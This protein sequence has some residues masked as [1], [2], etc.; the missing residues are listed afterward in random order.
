MDDE[1]L[2][3]IYLRGLV[4]QLEALQMARNNY[5]HDISEVSDRLRRL[6]HQLRGSGGSYGFPDI[7]IMAGKLEDSSPE[8]IVTHTDNLIELLKKLTAHFT[9]QK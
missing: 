9:F 5:V 6:A 3:S 2:K 8:S 1:E 7:T 4:S